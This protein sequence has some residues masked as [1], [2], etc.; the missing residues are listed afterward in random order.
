ML[1]VP[2]ADDG[3]LIRQHRLE[4]VSFDV[5]FQAPFQNLGD[6]LARELN[7][8]LAHW[9]AGAQYRHR[10]AVY[11]SHRELRRSIAVVAIGFAGNDRGLQVVH[12]E[13]SPA[14]V[15]LVLCAVHQRP[16][17]GPGQVK[18]DERE[19]HLGLPTDAC[20]V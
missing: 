19:Q 5:R 7:D 14:A 4:V 8:R 12:G 20:V 16:P 13:C 10:Q 9:V 18:R 3:R 2:F 17:C 11:C 1:L 15:R 6:A